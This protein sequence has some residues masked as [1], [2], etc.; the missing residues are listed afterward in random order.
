[1]IKI[2]G[3]DVR[4]IDAHVHIFPEDVGRDREA[5]LLRDTWFAQ[6]YANPASRLST[7]EDLIASMDA[8]GVD[9]S[10]AC[11][12]PWADNAHCRYHNEYMASAARKYP[13]RISWLGIVTPGGVDD[14]RFADDCFRTGASWPG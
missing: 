2:N 13:D 8:A 14:V 7:A 3:R 1:M 12:F 5:W 9:H 4:V 11:G 10:I 6:L